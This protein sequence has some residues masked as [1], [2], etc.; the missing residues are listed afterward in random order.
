MTRRQNRPLPSAEFGLLLVEGGDE[1]AVC[2]VLAGDAW[3]GLCGWTADGRESLPGLARLAT[4]DPNFARAR[5]VGIVLD[6]ESDLETARRL[7]IETLDVLGPT[8]AFVHGAL[9]GEPRI[10]AFLSPDGSGPG[11]IETLCRRAVRDRALADCIDQLVECAGAPHRAHSNPH[12]AADK[13]WLKA[14]LGMTL[15][16]DLRFHQELR[17]PQGIDPAHPAFIPLREFILAL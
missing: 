8:R 1:L 14:Y 10:G 13:G 12:A 3:S 11:S 17:H 5:A 2:E 16:P 6:A 9:R 15:A 4:L 7:A